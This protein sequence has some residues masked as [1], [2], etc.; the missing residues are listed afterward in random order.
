MSILLRAL[1]SGFLVDVFLRPLRRPCL[2]G[3]GLFFALLAVAT[4]AN[5]GFNWLI[6]P[7]PNNFDASGAL[8]MAMEALLILLSAYAMAMLVRRRELVWDLSALLMAA[9]IMYQ[10]LLQTPAQEWIEPWLERH[11]P[12]LIQPLFW[13]L[14]A[15]WFVIVLRLAA[16]LHAPTTWRWIV[17]GVLVFCITFVPWSFLPKPAFWNQDSIDAGGITADA[18]FSDAAPGNADADIGLDAQPDFDAEA[19]MYDQPRLMQDAIAKLVPHTPG[20]ANLYLIGFAGDSEENVFRNEVEFVEQQF[21]RRFDAAGH[22]LL[23]ENNVA[24]LP[25]RPIASLTNLDIALDAVAKKM[26]GDEDILLLF[27]TSHGSEDHQLYVDMDP[28]PLNQIAPEDLA[29]SLDKIPIRWKVIVISACYSGGFIDALKNST[30]MIITA[31]REDRTSF[32]CGADSDITWFSKAFFADALNQT[33]NFAAAFANATQH[34][35]EWETRDHEKSSYPQIVSTPLIEEKLK[36]WR[37]G[38][39]LGPAVPFVPVA[40]AKT[41]A[42]PGNENSGTLTVS[43]DRSE[44]NQR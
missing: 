39:H 5:I 29:E 13:L 15:W 21:I 27:L 12:A 7:I 34:I 6:T 30:T 33:D 28:L 17:A 37:S 43:I 9:A 18:Q 40:P 14:H 2:Q 4:L 24:T 8:A 32:G 23:L 16:R 35:T 20:K 22:T 38:I 25:N 10:I 31:A 42:D 36:Q 41:S 1:Y 11:Q 44:P 19:V 3:P 26:N